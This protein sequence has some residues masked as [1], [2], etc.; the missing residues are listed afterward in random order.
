MTNFILPEIG[1][2]IETVSISEILV[3]E[4]DSIKENDPVLLVETDK[5]S[6]EIPIDRDCTIKNI[7]V[8]IGD[9][10]SPGQK[11]L[12]IET[13]N[14][15]ENDKIS[16]VKSDSIKEKK[17][18]KEKVIEK[19][20]NIDL[21]N[22]PE[23]IDSSTFKSESKSHA[24]PS[25]RKLA[26]EL[27]CD[28]NKIKGSG[29]NNRITK[30]DIHNSM[31][32]DT[33]NKP[34]NQITKTDLFNNLAK[35]GLVEEIK[36]NSIRKTSAKRLTESWNT[37]PHVTQFEEVDITELDKIVKLLKKV[38]KNKNAKVSYLPFFIKAICI[39]LNKIPIFNSSF[40]SDN[41]SSIIQKHYYNVGIA[42]D[43]KKGLVVPVL[44]DVNKKSIKDI[45]I[46]LTQIIEKAKRGKLN[47][48]EMS[49]GS[50]T[51]SSLGNIGGGY[52]TPIINSPEVAIL[53][54]S[55][56]TI[57][58]IFENNKFVTKKM[59]PIS[60]SYDHRVI[61]GADAVK[62]TNLFSEL[63]SSPSKI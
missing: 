13:N 45:S 2:G 39:I 28:I 41:N 48:E 18:I 30:E 22:I 57:K 26:R 1:E 3:K 34:I 7:L 17:E 10:I 36:L 6:M 5:A 37:I 52:F 50:I 60:L 61:N 43:T 42:V 29:E 40:N 16:I 4:N 62:F 8:N 63:I 15:L 46:E 9:L 58:P 14:N 38:N 32:S 44:K 53:G 12:Q 19:E 35:W 31:K 23:V 55:K 49:G 21:D 11:I 20:I 25:V 51:I 59:L 47:L 33:D 56:I 24:S 54:I 27:G